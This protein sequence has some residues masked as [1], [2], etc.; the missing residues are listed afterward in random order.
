MA[1][2]VDLAREVERGPRGVWSALVR[3][4]WPTLL[5]AWLKS[6]FLL[7]DTL[8]AG[9]ISTTALAALSA[10]VFFVWMFHSLSQTNSIGT[11]SLMAQAKGAG[12]DERMRATLRRSLWLAPSLGA[13][14]ALALAF[15]GPAALAGMGLSADVVTDARV[16][17]FAIA[18]CGPGLWL[19]DT[20]EQAFRGAGDARTPL[21]V[22]AGFAFVN[23]A[24]NP[25]LAFGLGPL[26]ALGLL[27]I[28]LAS[29][30]SWLGGG[31]TLLLIARRRGML[32]PSAAAPPHP[33]RVWRIGMPTAL[34]G[35][36][37]DLVWVA[38]TPLIA[39]SGDG[40]VAA[41][42]IGHRLEG[43]SYQMAMG[44]GAA[45][46][47]LVG[48]AVGMQRPDLVRGVAYRSVALG[49]G[50][51]A[52]WLALIVATA[53]WTL[54]LFS[55]D[56]EVIGYTFDYLRLAAVFSVVQAAEV[57]F[58]GA[59]AGLGRTALPSAIALASY[60]ARVPLAGVLAGLYGAAGVFAAIGLTAASSGV[61]IGLA[62]TWVVGRRLRRSASLWGRA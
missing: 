2:A 53:P 62:F 25:L 43:L 13:A 46:A 22:A 7:A 9:R 5:S 33:W 51:S 60:G 56:P 39:K 4:A 61:L 26:P 41:V 59:F 6:S 45:C 47:S 1:L 19:F 37:F 57:I 58:V 3:M 35:V 17:L 49:L 14:A 15:V 55:K 34:A 18:A 28:A 20:V 11:L 52:L 31:A 8:V 29:G 38:I 23:F 50:L 27:G 36:A 48:Q 44:I 40:A 54:P 10:S 32:R 21:F 12:D 24:L 30:V 42:A 16:Y